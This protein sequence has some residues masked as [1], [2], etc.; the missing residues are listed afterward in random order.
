MELPWTNASP[1]LRDCLCSNRSL[2]INMKSMSNV[3]EV[4]F[5]VNSMDS[6]DDYNNLF[7]EGVW[8]FVKAVPC[9]QKRRVRGPSGEIKYQS[10][11][12]DEDE[13]GIDRYWLSLWRNFVAGIIV[14]FHRV[15]ARLANADFNVMWNTA[16]GN[17]ILNQCRLRIGDS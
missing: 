6:L 17:K 14:G 13:V 11:I 10:P 4:R 1:V 15:P 8:D 12:T 9:L 2:P 16:V 7:F 5:T 3:V